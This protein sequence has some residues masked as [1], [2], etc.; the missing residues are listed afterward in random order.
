MIARRLCLAF[1]LT[2]SLGAGAGLA[3]DRTDAPVVFHKASK[4]AEVELRLPKALA[5]WPAFRETLLETDRAKLEGFLRRSARPEE[6]AIQGPGRRDWRTVRYQLAGTT[7]RLIS[8]M[9][10]DESYTGGAHPNPRISGVLWDQRTKRRLPLSA[11]FRPDADPAPLDRALCEAVKA[12]KAGREGAAPIDG[13]SWK[14]PPF[15]Q[16]QAALAPSTVEGKAGGLIVL[17]NPYEVGPYSE[18]FYTVMVPLSA[19][20]QGLRRAYASEFAGAPGKAARE[21]A[22]ANALPATHRTRT[23]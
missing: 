10:L 11:L 18:G 12:A 8:V 1:A 7:P 6:G 19:L 2:A 5:A 13:K 23:P 3:A 16:A 14:C 17:I 22:D 4:R 20:R 9:R 15:S 21:L